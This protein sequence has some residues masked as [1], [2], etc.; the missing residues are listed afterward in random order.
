MSESSFS[1]KSSASD[2]ELVFVLPR[3]DYFNV[4]LRGVSLSATR[5][6]YAYTDA[7][8]LSSLFSKL[9]AT[10]RPW[11][12]AE[13]WQSLEGE[14]SISAQC[15]ALGHV[16]FAVVIRDQ[17]GGPEEW[18]VS[19]CITTDLGQLSRLATDAQSFFSAV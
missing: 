18:S 10:G 2:R 17:F 4:E 8:G 14:F 3:P 19:A 13:R 1:I 7:K 12:G 6:V 9:A 16:S 11:T 15:S 5:K